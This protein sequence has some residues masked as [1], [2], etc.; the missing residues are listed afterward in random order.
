MALGVPGRLPR[1]TTAERLQPVFDGRRQP[2]AVGLSPRRLRSRPSSPG[3]SAAYSAAHRDPRRPG[4]SPCRPR[5]PVSGQCSA[6][7]SPNRATAGSRSVS[8]RVVRRE[9]ATHLRLG[10][11]WH[12]LGGFSV[13][14]RRQANGYRSA[15]AISSGSTNTL[16]ASSGAS[17]RRRSTCPC[18]WVRRQGRAGS[19]RGW[20]VDS[21]FSS[22]H[23]RPVTRTEVP[24]G[25]L[26]HLA[27]LGER[28]R[29]DAAPGQQLA[30]VGVGQTLLDPRG[31]LGVEHHTFL[32]ATSR[33]RDRKRSRSRVAPSAP[34]RSSLTHTH[35]LP[36]SNAPSGL[37]VANPSHQPRSTRRPLI[38]P[39]EEP[40][41]H[42]GL[43]D[44]GLP[45]R[46]HHP[47]AAAN[48]RAPASMQLR[49][50]LCHDPAAG[51]PGHRPPAP[52]SLPQAPPVPGRRLRSKIS[53]K[54]GMRRDRPGQH[55][56]Q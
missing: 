54:Y 30:V 18:R 47:P 25:V 39:G 37:G 34:C 49:P 10:V 45:A 12:S 56:T 41:D 53:G 46:Q 28:D 55:T 2:G 31:D 42:R 14:G 32:L 29:G 51:P 27:V 33:R 52:E 50:A 11:G 7:Q 21:S 26:D 1:K 48:C 13:P 43:T 35:A 17:V 9:A 20:G 36:S 24:S 40:R 38:R 5:R 6:T 44:A 22:F 4:R 23:G 3:P 16:P 19:Q 15:K 8:V